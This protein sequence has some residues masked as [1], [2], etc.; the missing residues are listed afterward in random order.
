MTS[1]ATVDSAGDFGIN[2]LLGL[3]Q[4]EYYWL[5][6]PD[7]TRFVAKLENDHW[8]GVGAQWALNVTRDQV[9]CVVKAPEN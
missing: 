7:G 3:R 9:I 2:G 4:N 8:W 1:T 5:R 6:H